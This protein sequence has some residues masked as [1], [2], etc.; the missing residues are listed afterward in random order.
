MRDRI[1]DASG[2]I[3]DLLLTS[4][5]ILAWLHD[6]VSERARPGD[7]LRHLRCLK[8]HLDRAQEIPPEVGAAYADVGGREGYAFW[9]GDTAVSAHHAV[10]Q[11][12]VGLFELL[13]GNSR[14]ANKG[15]KLHRSRSKLRAASATLSLRETVKGFLAMQERVGGPGCVAKLPGDLSQRVEWEAV[16]TVRRV[17]DESSGANTATVLSQFRLVSTFVRK[18]HPF[19]GSTNMIKAL[20]EKNAGRIRTDRP[21]KKD[22]SRKCLNR[23]LVHVKDFEAVVRERERDALNAPGIIESNARNARRKRGST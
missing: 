19:L 16:E 20:I 14:P 3:R 12:G 1:Q 17:S 22:G 2:A 21:M 11:I 23:L 10:V 15:R 8:E 13:G 7:L 5:E 4:G 6:V 9:D 18:G